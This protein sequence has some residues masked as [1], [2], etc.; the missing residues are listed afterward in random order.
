[1]KQRRGREVQ[2]SRDRRGAPGRQI[3]S[4]PGSLVLPQQYPGCA[5]RTAGV[6]VNLFAVRQDAQQHQWRISGVIN[7]V[8]V[9]G[10][11]V[12]HAGGQGSVHPIVVALPPQ[13]DS[14]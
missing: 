6:S 2:A 7:A 8:G 12:G 3:S 1:M 5:F 11:V 4:V 13:P 10:T 9:L 14:T